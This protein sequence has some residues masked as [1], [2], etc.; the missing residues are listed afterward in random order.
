MLCKT[1]DE[2]CDERR[3]ERR[4]CVVMFC[5]KRVFTTENL[6]DDKKRGIK[7]ERR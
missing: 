3:D 1:L 2:E 6:E 7:K 5:D 4:W